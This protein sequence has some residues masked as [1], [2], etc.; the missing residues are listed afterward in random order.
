MASPSESVGLADTLKVMR[1]QRAMMWTLFMKGSLDFASGI[2]D[3][4][5]FQP[6]TS[7]FWPCYLLVTLAAI[8]FLFRVATVLYGI[9][10]ALVCAG[11]VFIPCFGT[12]T[13]LALHGFAID[14]LRKRDVRVGAMGASPGQILEVRERMSNRNDGM[15]GS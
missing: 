6:L 2:I 12:V 4:I 10:P 8:T 13:I 5:G 7:A 9:V 11:A 1:A 14:W 15:P 3:E